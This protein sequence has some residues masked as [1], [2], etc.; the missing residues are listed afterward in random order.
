MKKGG[1]NKVKDYI[2]EKYKNNIRNPNLKTEMF[3]KWQWKIM[4]NDDID[5]ILLKFKYYSN[6]YK[7]ERT[8]AS[9]FDVI[10]LIGLT[11][12]KVE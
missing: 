1:T 9:E 12:M 11:K 7:I 3:F 10:H 5:L 8:V 2:N 6:Y 4:Q